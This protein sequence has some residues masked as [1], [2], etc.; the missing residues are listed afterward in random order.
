MKAGRFGL[1]FL[2]SIPVLNLVPG[3]AK[4]FNK[5][6]LTDGIQALGIWSHKALMTPLNVHLSLKSCHVPWCFQHVGCMV[7]RG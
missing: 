5:Y 6:L 7:L 3:A 4:S 1:V 2:G